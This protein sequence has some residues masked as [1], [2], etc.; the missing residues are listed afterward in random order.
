MGR[1]YARLL[2]LTFIGSA[3][4]PLFTLVSNCYR[5]D[6]V[7]PWHSFPKYTLVAS[8][9]LLASLGVWWLLSRSESVLD[10]MGIE[11]AAFLQALP[12][13]YVSLSIFATAA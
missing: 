6:R 10:K 7:F 1:S 8:G 5:Q 4:A 9:I 12:E 11:E 3:L 13:R 2:T